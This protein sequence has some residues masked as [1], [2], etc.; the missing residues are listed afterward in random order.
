MPAYSVFGWQRPCYLL[1]EGYAS[2]YAELIR[3]TEWAR[4][5]HASGNPSCRDCMVHSGFEASA[6]EEAFS[7]PKGMLDMLLALVRGPQMP[8][9]IAAPGTTAASPPSVVGTPLGASTDRPSAPATRGWS[10]PAS[11]EA[12]RAAFD[13]RGDVTLT[14][15]DQSQITGY[16]MDP[17]PG[18]VRIWVDR[19]DQPRVVPSARIQHVE[20]SGRDPAA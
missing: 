14:L 3:E 13:Y 1:Q 20:L 16:A 11:F 8:K 9:S 17:G 19:S 15:D 4:Y 10:S 5:G 12:L 18:D 6:V 7:G 2:S